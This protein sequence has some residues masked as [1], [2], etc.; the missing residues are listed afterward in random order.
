MIVYKDKLFIG[1][2]LEY[3]FTK[4][5]GVIKNGKTFALIIYFIRFAL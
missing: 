1:D 5:E 2:K 3:D 4:K